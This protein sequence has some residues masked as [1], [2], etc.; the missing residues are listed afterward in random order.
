MS[1]TLNRSASNDKYN[2]RGVPMVA[3]QK[4]GYIRIP[5]ETLAEHIVWCDVLFITIALLDANDAM[6]IAATNVV[7]AHDAFHR[8]AFVE[9]RE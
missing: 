7:Y 5:M 1:D 3:D 9:T 8:D 6:N 2:E 4:F